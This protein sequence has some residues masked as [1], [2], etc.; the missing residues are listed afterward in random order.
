MDETSSGRVYDPELGRFMSADPFVQAPYNSQSYNRYSYVFNSTLSF[1][2]PSRYECYEFPEKWSDRKI[3]HYVSDI[4]TDP[5]SKKG[6]GKWD[7]PY[8]IGERDGV[9]IRVDFYPN[10]HQK[11]AGEI[12]TAYPL[13]Q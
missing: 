11:Y 5:K 6:N 13:A 8:A 2:D 12:S 10:N 3:L 9:L 4:A 7:S 1:T